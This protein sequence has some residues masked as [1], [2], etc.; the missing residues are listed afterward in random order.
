MRFS[1]PTHMIPPK[2]VSDEERFASIFHPL[3]SSADD[4][5]LLHAKKQGKDFIHIAGELDRSR[6]TVEQRWHRLRQIKGIKKLL[7][8]HGLTDMRYCLDGSGL[9][10]ETE[11]EEKPLLHDRRPNP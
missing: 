9:S 7:E 3:W 10:S 2:R 4:Y 5:H 8:Q 11:T 1:V 6:I